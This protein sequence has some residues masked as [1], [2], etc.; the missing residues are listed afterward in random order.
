MERAAAIFCILAIGVLLAGCAAEEKPEGTTTPTTKVEVKQ[1]RWATCDPSCYGY[2]VITEILDA[3]KEDMPGY[4]FTV[5]PYSSTTAA[6]KGFCKGEAESVYLADLG[7]KSLYESP[8]PLR[9]SSLKL[10]R[11]PSRPSGRTRWKLSS[12]QRRR[13]LRASRAGA[14]STESRFS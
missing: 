4:E 2:R 5:K 8:D 7:A 3:V 12:S 9:A 1:W 6:V 13:M 10:S 14:T 11:C